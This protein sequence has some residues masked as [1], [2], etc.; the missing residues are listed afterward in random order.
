M[1]NNIYS[2]IKQIQSEIFFEQASFNI[3]ILDSENS[4]NSLN[5]NSE[6][7]F[8]YIIA[9]ESND[10]ISIRVC[11]NKLFLIDFMPIW[12]EEIQKRQLDVSI[13]MIRET[14]L[15]EYSNTKISKIK[16]CDIESTIKLLLVFQI[17]VKYIFQHGALPK[18]LW[19][20]S[21]SAYIQ[22]S[23]YI[24]I[25]PLTAG[26]I[27]GLIDEITGIMIAITGF[28]E[29]LFDRTTE[30]NLKSNFSKVS[31]GASLI[32]SNKNDKAMDIETSEYHAS[33]AIINV[34]CM[35]NSDIR[36]SLKNYN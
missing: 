7:E 5:L 30:D 20:S 19:Y 34:G 33:K 36:N 17:T 35:L 31:I 23:K 22:W 14:L 25:K 13:E 6:H 21:D 32:E 18:S 3:I 4:K 9:V 29:I 10:T 16:H 28:G 2:I 8:N 24:S 1:I 26:Y 12:K 11:P 15:K 27:D